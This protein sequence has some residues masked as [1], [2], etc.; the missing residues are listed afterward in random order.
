M[1]DIITS[2]ATAAA[3]LD[4]ATAEMA[5]CVTEAIAGSSGA[6]TA[7]V[8]R[9]TG[10]VRDRGR[11]FPF[12]MIHKKVRPVSGGRHAAAAREQTHWAYWRREPL[13]YA[14]GLVPHGPHLAAP[15]CFGTTDDSVY[16]AEVTGP[17]ESAGTAAKR[18][19]AWQAGTP[20]PQVAWLG[21]P[22]L[23]QRIAVSSLDWSTV[24]AP[25]PLRRVWAHRD[26]LLHTL[27]RVPT[28]VCHGDFHC[29]NL[30]GGETVTT[31]LDWGTFSVG[32]I[33]S[34]LAHLALSTGEDHLDAY[35]EGLDGRFD[36]TMVVIG[37]H[38]TMALTATGR[39]HWM[40]ARGMPVPPS[41]VR[42]ATLGIDYLQW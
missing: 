42:L 10:R 2:A 31:V 22:Q 7:G 40:L 18:L 27:A 8:S 17:P 28:V 9:V 4:S 26:Q 37:Y 38:V 13:A 25:D 36:R 35:L 15:R 12:S 29:R 30:I 19:G 23:A 6:A 20:V 1:R 16:L 32:P 34:D 3:G 41:Y 33:G 5:E 14:A 21:G 24:D 11:E 39:V